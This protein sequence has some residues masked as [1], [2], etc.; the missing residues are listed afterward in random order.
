MYDVC[1]CGQYAYALDILQCPLCKQLK[2]TQIPKQVFHY[3][4]KHRLLKLLHSNLKPFF[5]YP[6]D[7][8]AVNNLYLE[9]IYDGTTYK[10]FES[11]MGRNE[12]FI[13][14]QWCWD[15]AQCF[16]DASST[17]SFWPS[18]VCILNLPTDLRSKLHIGLRVVTLCSGSQYS[19]QLLVN[20]LSSLWTEGLVID[21]IKFR[22]GLVNGVWDG[23]AFQEVTKTEGSKSLSGCNVCTFEGIS[24][25]RRVVYPSFSR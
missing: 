20:D 5:F 22:V 13:G 17:Q 6:R 24:F 3:P 12:Y 10:W 8:K 25:S 7:R 11:Q 16:N 14:L 19:L 4:L 21:G 23:I 15:G 9:D 2:S 1:K 18:T